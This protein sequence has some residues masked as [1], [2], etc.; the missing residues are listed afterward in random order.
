MKNNSYTIIRVLS[1]ACWFLFYSCSS[2]ISNN[3]AV[4]QFTETENNFGKLTYKQKAEYNFEFTNPGKT[5]LI[6]SNVKTSCGCA[7]A[8]WTKEPVKP[9]HITVKYDAASP[10]VFQKT[11]TVHFNGEDSP[12]KLHI[13]GQVEYPEDLENPTE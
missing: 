13:K 2:S 6:I 4:I 10:G 3:N 11:I 12:V 7:A 5:P 8:D 9:G 1:I